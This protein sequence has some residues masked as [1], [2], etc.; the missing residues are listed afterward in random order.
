MCPSSDFRHHPSVRL[1]CL[2]L[3][4]DSLRE[5]APVARHQRRRA[6]VARGFK[7][8]DHS[9]FAPGP[10]PHPRKMH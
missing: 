4:D 1:V 6:V 5:N 7:A 9:H 3:T 10:L 8:E 2:R